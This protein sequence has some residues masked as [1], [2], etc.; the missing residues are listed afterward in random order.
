[1][2]AH[3]CTS[4]VSRVLSMSTQDVTRHIALDGVQGLMIQKVFENTEI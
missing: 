4:H 3:K 1:M 2:L